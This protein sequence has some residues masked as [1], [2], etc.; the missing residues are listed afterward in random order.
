MGPWF[1]HDAAHPFRPGCSY[2]TLRELIRRGRVSAAT[3]LR[4]PATR[5]FW[6]FAGRTPGIANLLGLCHNCQAAVSPDA[7]ACAACGAVFTP[8]TDRQHLGLAPVHLLPGQAAP[9]IIAAA[10]SPEAVAAARRAAD[11]AAGLTGAGVAARSMPVSVTALEERRSRLPVVAAAV[12]AGVLV[13]LG[14]AAVIFYAVRDDLAAG[15]AMP[16]VKPEAKPLEGAAPEPAH[17]EAPAVQPAAEPAPERQPGPTPEEP[18]APAAAPAE[19]PPDP[20][21]GPPERLRRLP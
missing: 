12:A 3:V 9:E 17:A 1:L 20:A 11:A 18:G 14:S 13:G 8:E 10:Q 5:Q 21:P 7:Y 2:E 4:G 6:S 19:L 16:T 15:V